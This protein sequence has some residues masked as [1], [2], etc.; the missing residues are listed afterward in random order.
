MSEGPQGQKDFLSNVLVKMIEKN[1][2][3]ITREWIRELESRIPALTGHEEFL[4]RMNRGVLEAVRQGLRDQG[5]AWDPKV[6]R[7]AGRDLRRMRAGLPD[8][9]NAMALSRK[10]IW[11]HV[12]RKKILSSLMEIYITLELNNRIIFI[13]D[14]IIY[15]LSRGYME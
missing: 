10:G 3:E 12:V 13:Y 1:S 6:F 8:V 15:H 2:E 5:G 7:Q 11:M 14:R 9:L 4:A